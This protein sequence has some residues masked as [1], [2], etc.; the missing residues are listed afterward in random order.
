MKR[1]KKF[2]FELLYFILFIYLF[3]NLFIFLFTY[4]FIYL[5][6]LIHFFLLYVF[7]FCCLSSDIPR[8]PYQCRSSTRIAQDILSY[9]LQF[10]GYFYFIFILLDL[11]FCFVLSYQI[12]LLFIFSLLCT[13]LCTPDSNKMEDWEES[14]REQYF[15][16][17]YWRKKIKLHYLLL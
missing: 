16:T 10:H 2:L 9:I 4:L 14:G 7:I 8:P 11:F 17:T 5:F 15:S 3:I 13:L 6:L 1:K 12:C